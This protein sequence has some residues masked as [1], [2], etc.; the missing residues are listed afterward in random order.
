M[1]VIQLI[2]VF[3]RNS[4]I[5]HPRPLIDTMHTPE[6]LKP[7]LSDRERRILACRDT[8]MTNYD[9]DYPE[10]Q[11]RLPAGQKHFIG[12]EGRFTIDANKRM[13]IA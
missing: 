6:W 10:R 2:E 12:S 3:M 9:E 13:I 1:S 8:I 4:L 5:K 11:N 7:L